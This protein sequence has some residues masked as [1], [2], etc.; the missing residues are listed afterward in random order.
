MMFDVSSTGGGTRPCRGARRTARDELI[1][2]PLTDYVLVMR[3][4]RT[5]AADARWAR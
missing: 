2:N 5:E 3:C 1:E 4:T